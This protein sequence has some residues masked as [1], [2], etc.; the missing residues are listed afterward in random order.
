MSN[1]LIILQFLAEDNLGGQ[2]QNA[3]FAVF[4][5]HSGDRAA[6]F[7]SENLSKKLLKNPFL[8]KDT[9]QAVREGKI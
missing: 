7:C 8:E 3:S 6:Q 9:C 5:G 2:V 4:D 1:F